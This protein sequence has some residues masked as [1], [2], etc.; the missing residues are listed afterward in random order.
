METTVFD[1][2]GL[3]IGVALLLYFLLLPFR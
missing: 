2:I 1:L 3:T